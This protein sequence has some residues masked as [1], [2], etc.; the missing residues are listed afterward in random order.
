MGRRPRSSARPID[1]LSDWTHAA[2]GQ[3][4]SAAIK[5]DGTL[6]TWGDYSN[7]LL[8]NPNLLMPRAVTIPVD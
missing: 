1:T 5:T 4:A 2:A 6:W 7:G 8:G 3:N